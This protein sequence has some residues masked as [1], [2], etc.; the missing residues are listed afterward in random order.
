MEN[1]QQPNSDYKYW[2]RIGLSKNVCEISFGNDENVL[3]LHWVIGEKLSL[4]YIF[5]TGDMYDITNLSKQNY[6]KKIKILKVQETNIF[7]HVMWS[8]FLTK[9]DLK[10]QS[11]KY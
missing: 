9:R 8:A 5:K 4:I 10:I 11:S 2:R 3:M 1:L 6:L 7:N